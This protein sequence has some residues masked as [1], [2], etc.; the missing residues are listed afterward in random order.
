[1][2]IRDNSS[3]VLLSTA[4]SSLGCFSHL[5]SELAAMKKGLE[6]ARDTG[7]S[8]LI[9]ESDSFTLVKAINSAAFLLS[10]VGIIIRDIAALIRSLDV[11]SVSFIP[12]KANIFADALAKLGLCSIGESIWMEDTPPSI[13]PLVLKDSSYS[14]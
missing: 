4:I 13:F 2:V 3:C 9:V 7:F 6:L 8:R 1:M 14:L 5:F 11:F 10:E 12:R